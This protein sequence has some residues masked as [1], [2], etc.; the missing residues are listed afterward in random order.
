MRPYI[1]GRGDLDRVLPLGWIDV[2]LWE[3]RD[4]GALSQ[5]AEWISY[6]LRAIVDQWEEVDML[7]RRSW[8]AGVRGSLGRKVRRSLATALI[9]LVVMTL[10][11]PAGQLPAYALGAPTPL[12]PADGTV[13]TTTSNPPLGIPEFN[14]S[15]VPGATSYRLQIS[16][17]I[18]FTTLAVNITTPNPRYTPTSASP[19]PD[20]TWYW[21]VR[22]EAPAPASEYSLI[23][24]FTKQWASATNAPTL[25]APSDGATVSFYDDPIFSWQPVT[26]A[27]SYRVQFATTASGF[28]SPLYNQTTLATSHQPVTKL[29]NGT[30]YW[31]IVPLDPAD[32]E[33][34]AS[35]VRAFNVNYSQVPVLLEPADNATPTFTPTFRWTAVRGAEKYRLQYS[36]D[37]NLLSSVT[38]VD[39]FNTT[40]TPSTVLPNDVNY[41]WHVAA[42]SGTSVGVY[43][44]TRTFRKQWYIQPELLTPVNSYQHTKDAFFSW[45]PVPSA[46]YYK[47]EVNEINSFPPGSSGWSLTTPNTFFV[48]PDWPWESKPIWY[49][50]V[51]PYDKNNNAGVSSNVSSF[52]YQAAGAPDLIY[53]LFYYPPSATL[54]PH[55][56]RT[57]ALPVFMWQRLFYPTNTDQVAAYRV[58]VDDDSLFGSVNWTFDTQNMSA[59]PT[60]SAP[61]TPSNGGIYYWRVRPLTGIGIGATEIGEWSQKWKTRIDTTNGLAATVGASPTLLRPEPGAEAMEATP[62]FEWWPL[63]GAD[64]YDVQISTATDFDPAYIVDSATVFYPVYA[65][66]TR[67]GYGT[68]YWRVRGRTGGTPGAWSGGWRFQV[69]AQSRWRSSRVVGQLESDNLLVGNDPAGDVAEANYDLTTL[70]AAQS[71]DYWFFG[72]N[73]Q[74]TVTDTTYVLYL[75][76]D[77]VDGSG[78]T[79]D[80]RGY[81]VGTIAAH[82][83]EYAVYLPQSAGA[84][85]TDTVAIYT[86]NGAGWN[87]PQTLADVGGSLSY[88]ATINYVEIALPSTAI[89]MQGDTGSA[90]ISLF[91]VSPSGTGAAKDTVPS[92]PGVGETGTLS[93][94]T[95]V[96]ERMM[97]ALP[98]SNATG[99]PT[100]FPTVMPFFWHWP[101]DT[102]WEGFHLQVARDQAFTWIVGEFTLT[103]SAPYLPLPTYTYSDNS[104]NGLDLPSDNTYYWRVRP[105]YYA[106]LDPRGAWSQPWRFERRGFVPENLQNSVTFATPTL[107]WDMVEGAESYQIQVDNDPSFNSPEV[108]DT[109]GRNS[110]TPMGTLNKGTYYWRVR[111]NRRGS[112]VND[113][114]PTQSFT[115]SLPQPTG[116]THSPAGVAARAPTLCWTPLVSPTVGNPVLA[117]WRYRVQVSK[118]DPTF[119]TTYD[120]ILTEQACWTPTKGY[121]DGTYYWRVSMLDGQSKEGIYSAP[122][123]FTKQYPVTTLLEPTSGSMALGT[124]TFVWTPVNGAASYRLEVSTYPT[125]S[126]LYESVTTNNT[127]YTPTKSYAVGN[128]YYWRVAIIDKDNKMG[129]FNDATIIVTDPSS[130]YKV[131]LPAIMRNN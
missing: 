81:G 104:K 76:L 102:P 111:V 129:P 69:A 16:G 106:T 32:R 47:I 14:W 66:Q 9:F 82:R 18:G 13:T 5:K 101:I 122:V 46:S 99:D 124:P 112:V 88:S 75:D 40:Y 44:E 119:S 53:P 29:A 72:F 28:N 51:I 38:T 93:R 41:Y 105:V 77:H 113:W 116:L 15:P 67:L 89:G 73:A 97:P 7:L 55:E 85:V 4:L 31:R 94:F 121:D 78:A 100:D 68:Y 95:S 83:P 61:F 90:A 30:Y 71:R 98:Q 12:S 65:P 62:L 23:M 118:G 54:Q 20:G 21:R 17:N 19:L 64:S 36:T 128:T 103:A 70:Y 91:S 56:D 37:P 26:G 22:V 87:T 52:G 10:L 1:K 109:T 11:V 6:S 2:S 131:F 107:S 125:F 74:G 27:A 48:R 86:W 42:L 126:S 25:T 114:T 45:T 60:A 8:V 57:V 108:S 3:R 59:A 110:Y 117:A 35:E 130:A 123:E 24:S 34:W 63:Q 84:F 96:S 92:H 43:S 50:R 49:W 58:Q 127:R 33:G 120:T 115:L 39:T 79:G 80:A